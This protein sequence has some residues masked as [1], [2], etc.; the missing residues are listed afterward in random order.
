MSGIHTSAEKGLL[1]LDFVNTGASV[2]SADAL[3]TPERASRWLIE[4]LPA[5]GDRAAE[6]S[7]PIARRA[8]AEAWQLRNAID[9]LFSAAAEATPLPDVTLATL[10]RALRATSWRRRL[11]LSTPGVVWFEEPEYGAD[12][13]SLLAPIALSATEL[14]SSVERRRLRRCAADDC[15]RWFIDKSK[16]GR[17]RW[18]SMGTCGNRAKAARYRKRHEAGS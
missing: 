15:E 2:R 18:C 12:P 9:R 3:G 8:H 17:R 14:L 11:E 10:D 7:L 6:V 13:L 4:H 16:G 5:R 1:A